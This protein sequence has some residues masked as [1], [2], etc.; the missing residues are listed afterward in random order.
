MKKSAIQTNIPN[1]SFQTLYSSIKNNFWFCWLLCLLTAFLFA[2]LLWLPQFGK[3]PAGLNRDEAALGYNAYSILKTGK[4]EWG[5]PFP[6]SITSFG[7][8]K[9]PGYV[10]TLIPFIALFDL[11][12]WVIRLPSLLAGYIIIAGMG[13]IA[14]RVS[15]DIGLPKTLQLLLSSSV[16]IF[17]ATSPWHMHF[18]RV[19]YES[20]LA[21]AFFVVGIVCWLFALENSKIQKQ[22][23]LLI[24]SAVFF[25]LTLLTYHSYQIFTPLF[26][27]VAG[28]IYLF[29]IKRLDKVALSISVGVACAAVLLIIN[30]GIL[31]ANAVKSIGTSP[32]SSE[33]LLHNVT[34]W[35]SAAN[36]PFPLD[37]LFFNKFTEASAILGKNYFSTFSG[38]FYFNHGSGHGDHNPGYMNNLH[39]VLAP[40]I[41]FGVLSLWYFRKHASI[42]LLSAWF[43]IALIPSALTIQPLHEIRI[44]TVFPVLEFIAALGVVF[45]FQRLAHPKIR[46]GL[47]LI[48]GFLLF[49]SVLRSFYLYTIINPQYTSNNTHYHLLAST[50]NTY[51]Q[52]GLDVFTN[53][54]SSS[55]Y[56][57]YLVENIIDPQIVHNQLE[58]H[59]PTEEGFVH[60]S[61]VQ[62]IY[63]ETLNW[64]RLF[65]KARQKPIYLIVRPEHMP[66]DKRGDSHFQL[67]ES[68]TGNNG[69]VLYEVWKSDRT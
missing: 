28:A 8:Q 30:G 9:L 2:S 23:L 64:D 37:K 43:L 38:E 48:T 17:T 33:Q 5:T 58:H 53:S 51:R 7:D 35:R 22:R 11:S 46:Y 54:E 68:I 50:L 55:P 69:A 34:L 24:L 49:F 32:L 15:K 62:N 25:S 67:I 44:A 14:V 40:F 45:I 10:Y 59:A 47:L 26:V 1:A 65:E 18:S 39:Q 19:A 16:M 21:M 13:I 6:V 61:R 57:W 60:V 56:I 31:K 52:L 63:F 27:I 36:L 4:D 29:R 41:F 42:K 20:H 3:L 12:A 66:A